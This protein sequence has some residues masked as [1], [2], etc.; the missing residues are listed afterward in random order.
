[1]IH[2][3]F[4]D[5]DQSLGTRRGRL[6]AWTV[7]AVVALCLIVPL[8]LQGVSC[9]HDFAFHLLSWMEVAHQFHGGTLHPVWAYTPSF[10]AGEPRFVFYP[11]LSWTIGAALT[12]LAGPHRF[13][14]VPVLYTWIALFA[15]G[16]AM[17]QLAGRYASRAAA[18]V[19][20]AAYMANPYMLFTAYERTAYAELLAAA[21]MPL[22]L[23]AVLR[24][25]P[26]AWQIGCAVGLLWIT[27][28][29]AAVAG[30]YALA[31]IAVVRLVMQLV[32]HRSAEAQRFALHIAG[33]TA[34]GLGLASFYIVP[35]VVERPLVLINMANIP[36]MRIQDNT[37]F[38]HTGDLE[39]DAVLRT[40]SRI[41]VVLLLIGV[42]CLAE[43]WRLSRRRRSVATAQPQ[44]A[45]RRSLL[46]LLVLLV[47]VIA[48]MLTPLSL[49]VWQHLPQ[50]GFLQFSWRLLAVL[51]PVVALLLAIVIS[52]AF[53]NSPAW[54][55]LT[56]IVALC[57]GPAAWRGFGERCEVDKTPAAVQT[58]FDS[59]GGPEGTDEYTPTIADND[60]LPHTAPGYW[61]LPIDANPN[62]APPAT[63][64]QGPGFP[65]TAAPVQRVAPDGDQRA[66]FHLQFTTPAPALLVLHLRAYPLWH[67]L[68]NGQPV[69]TTSARDDGL[70]TL[71]VPAGVDRVDLTLTHSADQRWGWTVS[72]VSMLVLLGLIFTERMF[73]RPDEP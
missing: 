65:A 37:L 49:P 72:G 50:L 63:P 24:E 45:E 23:L 46:L 35:A 3:F 48:F 40:A 19:A 8:L 36:S 33:G 58:L 69:P 34:L 55:P 2:E 16:L 60:A 27:N 17:R 10:D 57:A 52:R 32:R 20:A 7:L 47:G 18:L 68:R 54:L 28:A 71:R 41:A 61:L 39:H 1:M 22:L 73:A 31:L 51:A 67:V 26:R 38:H 62:S 44:P 56:L 9:G 43:A 6:F 29:P 14:L 5:Q 4:R 30:C 64:A 21:W 11:P 13:A 25:R 12:L 53:Q 66:P 42:A 59:G 15:S 70:L